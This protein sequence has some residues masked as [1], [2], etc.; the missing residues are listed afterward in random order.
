[1]N[2]KGLIFFSFLFLTGSAHLDI[3]YPDG[4]FGT[5]ERVNEIE[6]ESERKL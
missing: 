6:S 2:F 1:M 5:K 3:K 4:K